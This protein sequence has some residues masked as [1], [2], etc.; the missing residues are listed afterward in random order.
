MSSVTRK[1]R[2]LRPSRLQKALVLVCS[3]YVFLYSWCGRFFQGGITAYNLAQKYKHPGVKPLHAL[4]VNG[5]SQMVANEMAWQS[6]LLFASH[7]SIGITGMPPLFLNQGVHCTHT[8][9]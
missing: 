2:K 3:S 8:M 5:V 1:K 4:L 7:S 9:P 6:C